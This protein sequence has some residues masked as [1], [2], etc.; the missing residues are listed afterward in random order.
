MPPTLTESS[1]APMPKRKVTRAR[2]PKRD[3]GPRRERQR[4]TRM[5]RR[6]GSG[7]SPA[8]LT[9]SRDQLVAHSADREDVAG[10]GRVLLD[11]GAQPTDVHVDQPPVAEVV[12]APDPVE[13]LLS[14][15]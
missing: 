6:A 2:T 15:Q 10:Q 12:V 11:L 13:Q 8:R 3:H 4:A 14:R 1:S 7:R 9:T 5:M